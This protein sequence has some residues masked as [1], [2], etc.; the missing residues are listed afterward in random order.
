L[1]PLMN[2]NCIIF[3]STENRDG[4]AKLVKWFQPEIVILENYINENSFGMWTG[5]ES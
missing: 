1:Y 4:M 2:G 3:D 5:D